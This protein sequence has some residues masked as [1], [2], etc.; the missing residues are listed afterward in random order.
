MSENWVDK[1]VS[2]PS[3]A[4]VWKKSLYNMDLGLVKNTG[5][6]PLLVAFPSW[7]DTIAIHWELG[8]EEAV[9]PLLSPHMWCFC[10]Y[11]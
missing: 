5:S 1:R 11:G 9:C 3:I 6:F 2:D 10:H 8:G 7:G 4:I